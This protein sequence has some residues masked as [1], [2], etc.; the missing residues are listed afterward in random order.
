MSS[1]VERNPRLNDCIMAVRMVRIVA[2]GLVGPA[3]LPAR[4]SRSCEGPSPL[5]VVAYA[6]VR[7]AVGCFEP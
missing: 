7:P 2:L 4:Q 6:R 5:N 3:G 1:H